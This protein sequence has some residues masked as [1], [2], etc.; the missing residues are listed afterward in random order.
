MSSKLQTFLRV[1]KLGYVNFWR[2]RWLTLG[3]ALLM[4]L[5]LT[6]I[7]VSLI[8]TYVVRDSADA[9]RSKIDITVYFRDDT[10]PDTQITALQQRIETQPNVV[11]THLVTK[12]EALTIFHRLAINEDIKKPV[13]TD[14]NPLPRS[15]EVHTANPDDISL[16]VNGLTAIDSD[17]I[18]CDECVSYG[19]NKATIERLLSLT[20]FIQKAG[21]LLSLFF[22][23][24]AIFNVLNI[25]RITI[26]ARS[27]EIEV[28]R[29]V[30]ASNSFIRGPFIIEGILYGVLGTFFTTLL[31]LLTAWLV[32]P[33]ISQFF[34]I[35]SLDLY[36]YVL[37][38]LAILIFWQLI[39]GVL[40]GALVSVISIRRYLRA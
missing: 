23:L 22:G 14:N 33:H 6:M 9:I 28:M 12:A 2:N 15:I 17:K 7:S 5:T 19:Q 25:I 13:T 35:L 27:D 30:G 21:I 8:L 32:S 26:A 11:T 16:V 1:F 38:L 34:S 36:H 29:F 3:A 10:V 31:I 18:I 40:L 20:R 4:T 39:I 37:H 24:I